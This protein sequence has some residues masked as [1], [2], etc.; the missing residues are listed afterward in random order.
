MTDREYKGIK[1]KRV[2]DPQAIGAD[3]KLFVK[4]PIRLAKIK[5]QQ[6]R[7]GIRWIDGFNALVPP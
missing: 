2:F 4:T 6:A 3:L 5:S 7:S 1:K